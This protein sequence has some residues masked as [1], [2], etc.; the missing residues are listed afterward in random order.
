MVENNKDTDAVIAKFLAGT[1]NGKEIEMLSGWLNES[2]D[3]VL[4]FM[5]ISNA[6]EVVAPPFDPAS[7]DTAAAKGMVMEHVREIRRR[8]RS[9][10]AVRFWQKTAAVIAFPL[11]LLSAWLIYDK[12]TAPE[13]ADVYQETF[14]PYGT[15]STVTLPDGSKV[16]LNAGSR[17]KYPVAFPKNERVVE[18]E[19]EVFFEVQA[20]RTSPFTVKAAGTDISAFGT[21]F[22]VE[23]Y[24]GDK[25]MAVTLAEGIV[26]VK[27]EENEVLLQP[28]ERIVL[29]RESGK[30]NVYVGDIYK[31]YAWKDGVMAFRNDPLSYV[32]KRLGQTYNIDFVVSRDVGDYIYHAT[33]EGE[34]LDEILSL[35]EKSAPISYTRTVDKSNPDNSDQKQ[36][37]IV[38]R[39]VKGS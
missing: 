9:S 32:F 28:R 11:T 29:D 18:M 1:A 3:N 36:K 17:L 6:W 38:R 24:P 21:E 5:Q 39:K 19:G 37:I 20:D 8:Q 35:L 33:F 2:E 31:W 14:A 30:H 25:M 12:A 22:N 4:R 16:W 15:R 26:G 27:W 10:K 34:S 7:I 23:A 13:Y